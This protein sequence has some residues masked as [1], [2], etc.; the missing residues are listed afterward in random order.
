VFGLIR[1][2]LLI[3]AAFVAG[4]FYERD[5]AREACRAAGGVPQAGVCIGAAAGGEQ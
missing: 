5:Q 3:G 4:V 1:L 2:P